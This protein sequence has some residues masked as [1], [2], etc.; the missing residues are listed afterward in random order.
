MPGFVHLYLGEEAIAVGVCAVLRPDDLVASTHRGHGHLIAKGGDVEPMMAELYG[1]AAGYS[2][3][4][5]GSMHIFVPEIGMLGTNGIVAAGIPHAVGAALSCKLL[6]LGRVAVAFFGDGACNQ[7]VFFESMNLAAL[8]ALP[9]IFVLENNLYSE[10]T[11]S[12]RLTAGNSLAGRALPF[13][14]PAVVVDGNDVLAVR[15][16]AWEAVARAR[17]G[18]GPTLI[19]A[20][21]YYYGGHFEGEEFFAGHYRSE[22]DVASWRVRDPIVRFGRTL[23]DTG[24][25]S[26]SGLELIRREEAERVARAVDSAVAADPPAISELTTDVFAD[27]EPGTHPTVTPVTATS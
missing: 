6:G 5:G 25:T 20:R 8:W 7:G 12:Q 11:E 23:V 17:C 18:Q 3:G 1:R 10:W 15:D 9:V 21:T 16:A 13:G 14:I 4:K 22:A 2:K 19:E 27:T 24:E 26:D